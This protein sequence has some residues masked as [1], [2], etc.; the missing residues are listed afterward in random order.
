MTTTVP[1]RAADGSTLARIIDYR[2]DHIEIADVTC[3]DVIAGF[4][5]D[6]YAMII[7]QVTGRR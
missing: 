1:N 2:T 7:E 3:A 4:P 6:T 5:R